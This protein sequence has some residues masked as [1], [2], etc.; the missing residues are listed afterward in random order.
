M[1]GFSKKQ[2]S[3]LQAQLAQLQEN[4]KKQEVEGTSGG[5]AVLVKLNGLRELTQIKIKPECI[6]KN[7]IEGL[8]LLIVAAHNNALKK[9]EDTTQ[10][11]NM[12]FHF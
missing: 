11:S 1:N 6:D 12:P 9:L 2:A 8:E 10:N 7:D 4:L 5:S 3:L